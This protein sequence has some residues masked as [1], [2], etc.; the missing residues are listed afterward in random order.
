MPNPA[1]LVTSGL[2]TGGLVT[3]GRRGSSVPGAVLALR[4]AGPP[5]GIVDPVHV[6]G[7]DGPTA[8]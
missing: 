2:V 6:T 5:A 1:D 7:G 4:F 3:G 8:R